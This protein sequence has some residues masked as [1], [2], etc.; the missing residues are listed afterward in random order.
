[1]YVKI[2]DGLNTH[3]ISLS[4]DVR[5]ED[6]PTM[7]YEEIQDDN[8]P[9]TDFLHFVTVDEDDRPEYHK[10]GVL[11]RPEG[12]PLRTYVTNWDVYLLSDSGKTLEVVH[13]C[14]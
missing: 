12:L 5:F 10:P 13:R 11:I 9:T 7:E 6:A 3:F 8:E 14:K 1:M 2:T 4:G